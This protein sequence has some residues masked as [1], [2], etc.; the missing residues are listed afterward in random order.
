MFV[1]L[2]GTRALT[3]L[4]YLLWV[5]LIHVVKLIDFLS[6]VSLKG[7]FVVYDNENLHTYLYNPEYID[8]E[9]RMYIS[10]CLSLPLSPLNLF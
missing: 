7:V 3:R 1:G 6:V 4:L 5:V 2:H 9:F 8:G 10:L